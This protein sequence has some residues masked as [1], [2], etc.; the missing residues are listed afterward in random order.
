M[1]SLE[2][3]NPY[4]ENNNNSSIFGSF[5]NTQNLDYRQARY[6][7]SD[8]GRF[9]SVDTLAGERLTLNPYNYVSNNPISRIDPNGM[10]DDWVVIKNSD[11]TRTDILDWQDANRRL[12][13]QITRFVRRGQWL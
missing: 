3:V 4:R 6:Y 5:Q 7:D 1:F 10:L 2:S 8:I 9:L 11:G 13:R 12:V